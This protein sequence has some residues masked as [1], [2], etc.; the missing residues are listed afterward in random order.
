MSTYLQE[1]DFIRHMNEYIKALIEQLTLLREEVA[2]MKT[3]LSTHKQA[4]EIIA[5]NKS[6]I[7]QVNRLHERVDAYYK[8]KNDTS[9][10]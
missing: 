10:F 7:Q 8:D 4:D 6:N 2:E 9:W 1:S 5:Q 3:E